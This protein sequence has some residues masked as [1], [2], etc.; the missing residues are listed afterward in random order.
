[1]CTGTRRGRQLMGG[2]HFLAIEVHATHVP[3]LSPDAAK[4]SPEHQ[5]KHHHSAR[6]LQRDD[7]E[8]AEIPPEESV[9]ART[10]PAAPWTPRGGRQPSPPAGSRRG[11]GD[12]WRLTSPPGSPAASNPPPRGADAPPEG[13][14]R[15]DPAA[16][17]PPAN[18]PPTPCPKAYTTARRGGGLTGPRGR[19][20]TASLG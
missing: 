2:G 14:A 3:G 1:L 20:G 4:P 17:V 6:L 5:A 11:R 19:P 12:S 10:R 13:V 7:D 9:H 18:G 15:L 16:V 8:F